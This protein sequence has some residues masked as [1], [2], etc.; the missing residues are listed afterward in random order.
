MC[1]VVVIA[2]NAERISAAFRAAVRTDRRSAVGALRL[3]AVALISRVMAG[4]MNDALTFQANSS[5]VFWGENR[6]MRTYCPVLH[7]RWRVARYAYG[8]CWRAPWEQARAQ[9]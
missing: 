3:T 8:V 1:G 5:K 7:T 4:S 2:H 9:L 6:P